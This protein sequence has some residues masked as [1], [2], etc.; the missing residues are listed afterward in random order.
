MLQGRVW[1]TVFREFCSRPQWQ[2]KEPQVPHR[3]TLVPHCSSVGHLFLHF[4]VWATCHETK[5][6]S[7]AAHTSG[8]CVCC[9][10]AVLGVVGTCFI[11][12]REVLHCADESHI[13]CKWSCVLLQWCLQHVVCISVVHAYVCL[14]IAVLH[15]VHI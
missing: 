8:V 4:L 6:Q 10:R 15:T 9:R 3:Q 11:L 5:R 12:L 14:N 1:F 7:V 13:R 2:H